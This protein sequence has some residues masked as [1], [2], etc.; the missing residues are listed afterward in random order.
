LH[1][2]RKHGQL[3]AKLT[4]AC[5]C[6]QGQLSRTPKDLLVLLDSMRGSACATGATT[7]KLPVGAALSAPGVPPLRLAM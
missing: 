6:W 1:P 4:V 7:M 3:P 2:F 5:R